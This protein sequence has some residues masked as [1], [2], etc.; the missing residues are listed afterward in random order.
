[1]A[2][3]DGCA[4]RGH[5]AE[6]ARGLG[7]GAGGEAEALAAGRAVHRAAPRQPCTKALRRRLESP[8]PAS[9]TRRG[10]GAAPSTRPA[11][12]FR[13][14][15]SG[16]GVRRRAPAPFAA[17]GTPEASA[18]PGRGRWC[19]GNPTCRPGP[20]PGEAPSLRAHEVRRRSGRAA[21]VQL[22]FGVTKC[23]AART[24]LKPCPFSR[25]RLGVRNA[26]PSKSWG[27]IIAHNH[28]PARPAF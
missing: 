8:R 15:G 7:E 24:R 19:S 21:W 9:P 26:S 12:R 14:A 5:V 18:C 28:R 10:R 17:M 4:D 1:M 20:R 16:F 2:G 23:A 11:T 6:A 13:A 3:S 22:T 27:S 25:G